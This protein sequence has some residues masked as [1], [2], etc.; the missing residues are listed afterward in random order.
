MYDRLKEFAGIGD[1]L[2]RMGQFILVRSYGVGGGEASKSQMC[3]QQDHHM[4]RVTY[5]TGLC[6]SELKSVATHELDTFN[7]ESPADFD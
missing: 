7:L 4:R 2:E 1:A 6:T 3:I 5:R